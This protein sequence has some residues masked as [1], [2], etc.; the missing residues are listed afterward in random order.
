MK[1]VIKKGMT[2][3]DVKNQFSALFPYLKLEIFKRKST[4]GHTMDED[5]VA[6]GKSLL[7]NIQPLLCTGIMSIDQNT[8]V[9]ELEQGF[10]N[11]FLLK[12]QVFRRSKNL[13][14][15]TSTTDVWTLGQQNEHARKITE[16]PSNPDEEL[17][18]YEL[19]R[20]ED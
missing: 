13:W 3:N 6:P 11:R 15:E 20:G 18:D 14:L 2:V 16:S 1:L 19:H 10:S 4:P 12:V 7:E 8:R 9:S 17:Q 5:S